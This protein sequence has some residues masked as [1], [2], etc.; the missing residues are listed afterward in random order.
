MS[1]EELREQHGVLGVHP[2]FRV[3]ATGH[4]PLDPAGSATSYP[5]LGP[6][7]LELFN[8]HHVTQ[9]T[10]QETVTLLSDQLPGLDVGLATK[11]AKVQKKLQEERHG[12]LKMALSTRQLLGIAAKAKIH[13][14][15]SQEAAA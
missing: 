1:E 7:A 11:L 4:P 2:S 9:P 14:R 5:P 8:Y 10:V 15:E 12:H 13:A 6:C 3:V